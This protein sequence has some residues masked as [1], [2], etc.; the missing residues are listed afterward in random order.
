MR[1]THSMQCPVSCND[2]KIRLVST[3]RRKERRDVAELM[4]GGGGDALQ[5]RAEEVEHGVDAAGH[6]LLVGEVAEDVD[7]L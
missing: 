1:R 5:G 7:Q 6:G 4:G 3:S 2:R